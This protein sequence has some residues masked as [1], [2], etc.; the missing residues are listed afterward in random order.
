MHLK[1][2]IVGYYD[3]MLTNVIDEYIK[4]SVNI[5]QQLKEKLLE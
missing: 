4:N 2:D 5:S 3:N 1:T